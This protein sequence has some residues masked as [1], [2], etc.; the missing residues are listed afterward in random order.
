VTLFMLLVATVKVLLHQITGQDDIVIGSPMAGNERGELQ[1]QIGFYLNNVVLRD[2]VRRREPFT[3]LLQRVR[4]SVADALAHQ[5][6]PFDLLI[7]ELAVAPA[8]G[9]SPLF[10]VQI[11]LMPGK[12][13]SL[14]LGDLVVASIGM[15][16]QTTIFDLNFMFSDHPRGL[17]VEIDYSTALFDAARIERLGDDLLRLLSFIPEQPHATVR[18]LC[19][20]L[21]APSNSVDKSE[22]LA[23]ALNL[24]EEF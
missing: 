7:R 17:A 8:P 10:D 18:S 12:P 23:A 24:D 3:T 16:N 11:N 20:L 21:E 19:G 15:D 1:G 9:H 5:D 4:H 14:Q 6:Y 2:T 22:F 13:P